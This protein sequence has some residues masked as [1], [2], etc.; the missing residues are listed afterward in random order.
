MT[1]S[2]AGSNKNTKITKIPRIDITKEGV[3]I[4]MRNK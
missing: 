2:S 4:L 3:L 1:F